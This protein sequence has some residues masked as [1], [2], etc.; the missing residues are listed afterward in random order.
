[1]ISL[2]D[3]VK[4]EQ[5]SGP[6]M[7]SRF[8]RERQVTFLA[9]AAP[10]ASEGGAGEAI[11][12]VIA[13]QKLPPAYRLRPTGQTKLM[14][15]TGISFVLGLLGSMVFMYLILAAQFESWLHPV[16][17]LLSLP[18]TLPFAILSVILFD[19]SLDVYSFLGIF[20]LFGIVKKNAI[21]QIVR[22][23]QLREE[24]T[25]RLAA[26]L[27]ANRD[28]L[29]PILMTTFAFVAGMIPLVT[30][31][32]IGA[33]F[34][35]ATAGVV[36]GGQ[37]MSLLLTLLAVPVAYSFFDDLSAATSRLF[38]RRRPVEHAAEPAADHEAEPTSPSAL[39]G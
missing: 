27:Q 11:A 4:L 33:G 12:K 8:Q 22:T 23:I 30:S 29:R 38:R 19:Q 21:L 13:D 9:N 6:A 5:G 28:R 35:R 14:A 24:G 15:E 36:V 26:I 20:V 17:I 7:I 3:V 25:P 2:E 16:T 1:M 18:L 32:G 10:G 37:V 34:N 31:R 39:T